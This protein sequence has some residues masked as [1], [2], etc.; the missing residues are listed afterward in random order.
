MHQIS[1]CV[2]ECVCV[3]ACMHGCV[4]ACVQM[5]WHVNSL[6]VCMYVDAFKL[7][8]IIYLNINLSKPKI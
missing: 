2:C 4:L 1:I 8:F 5:G 6:R 3:H 7:C